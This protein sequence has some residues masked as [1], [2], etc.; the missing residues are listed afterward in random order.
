M[1]LFIM[2]QKGLRN[3]KRKILFKAFSMTLA[4]LLIMSGITAAGAAGSTVLTQVNFKVTAPS[5]GMTSETAPE[6]T[7]SEKE[8]YSLEWSGWSTEEGYEPEGVITFEEGK[9]YYFLAK[10]KAADNYDFYFNTEAEVEFT[11]TG[12]VEKVTSVV[13]NDSTGYSS[14]TYLISVVAREARFK[15]MINDV[16]ISVNPPMEGQSSAAAPKVSVPENKG[17]FFDSAAWCDENGNELQNTFRFVGGQSYYMLVN[18]TAY[19]GCWWNQL[20]TLKT[21]VNGGNIKGVLACINS[22]EGCWAYAVIEVTAEKAPENVVPYVELGFTPPKS[23]TRVTFDPNSYKISATPTADSFITIPDGVDYTYSGYWSALWADSEGESISDDFTLFA[24]EKHY[25]DVLLKPASGKRFNLDYTSV[26]VENAEVV[27]A[28]LESGLL[29][30]VFSFVPEKN[31]ND[32]AVNFDPN[33]GEGEMS[34]VY[35]PAGTEYTLPEC[36]FTKAERSF[37][38]WEVNGEKQNPKDVI[39]VNADTVVKAVWQYTTTVTTDNTVDSSTSEVVGTLVL[40]D[41]KTGEET[42]IEVSRSTAASAFTA[43]TNDD[44]NA[45]IE[46]AKAAVKAEAAKYGITIED[47]AL[48]PQIQVSDTVDKRT[49]NPLF[50]QVDENGDYYTAFVMGGEYAHKWLITVSATVEKPEHAVMIG[51]A[52]GD[53][54]IDISDVTAIQR[55]VSEYEI[56]TGDRFIAADCNADG[57]ISIDDATLLQRFLAEF[58]VKLGKQ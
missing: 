31:A 56:L 29:Y 32:L 1:L 43:P 19:D 39:T 14:I 48:E 44:V 5:D 10:F 40:K 12:K 41:S 25:I 11:G 53:G 55:H 35:M 6:V 50:D 42:S 23:G 2:I 22:T 7:V 28:E 34:S 24:G 57:K 15:G 26:S 33:G 30:I 52:N 49:F 37:K 58:N 4:V 46:A 8:N 13:N 3:M 20:G 38:C 16:T 27:N 9:T 17:Y 54:K 47:D 36:A 18:L 45:L 21:T 51:D